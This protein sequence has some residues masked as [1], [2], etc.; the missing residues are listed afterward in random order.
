MN[1]FGVD[2]AQIFVEGVKTSKNI[3]GKKRPN[4]LERLAWNAF[5][6]II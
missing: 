3:A 6:S 2:E 1:R 4:L 5:H